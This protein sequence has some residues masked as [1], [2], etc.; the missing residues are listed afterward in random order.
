MGLICRAA[1]RTTQNSHGRFRGIRFEHTSP[2]VVFQFNPLQLHATTRLM[3]I[4]TGPLRAEK[5]RL[6]RRESAS[7]PTTAGALPP[8]PGHILRQFTSHES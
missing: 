3:P 4:P 8:G 7:A 2:F 5:L 6:N 1:F